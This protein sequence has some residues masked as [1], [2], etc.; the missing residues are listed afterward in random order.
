VLE[1]RDVLRFHP[2]VAPVFWIWNPIRI[3]GALQTIQHTCNCSGRKACQVGQVAC[4]ERTELAKHAH[5]F[6]IRKMKSQVF[7]DRLVQHHSGRTN[8]PETLFERF[9]Q[10]RPRNGLAAFLLHYLSH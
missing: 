8:V 2:N 10:F 4:G 9:Q 6:V 3:T 1:F 5:A 7:S